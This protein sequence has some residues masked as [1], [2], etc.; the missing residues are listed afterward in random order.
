MQVLPT[1]TIDGFV[2]NR[3]LLMTK[4]MEYF[5]AT[6]GNQS[7]VFRHKLASLKYILQ[8]HKSP[9]SVEAA[10]KEALENLYK[11]FFNSVTVITLREDVEDPN[12][13]HKGFITIKVDITAG[14]QGEFHTLSRL[15]QYSVADAHKFDERLETLYALQSEQ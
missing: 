7:D 5:L 1:L 3:A 2:E 14:Y 9:S 11:K 10:I 6:D 13:K 8:Q 15:L 12:K 4:L